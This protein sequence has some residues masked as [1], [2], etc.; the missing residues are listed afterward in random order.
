VKERLRD[1]KEKAISTRSF[2]LF[3]FLAWITVMG[4]LATNTILFH[5]NSSSRLIVHDISK[6]LTSLYDSLATK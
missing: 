6:M 4:L 2:I 5:S 1:Q 3:A